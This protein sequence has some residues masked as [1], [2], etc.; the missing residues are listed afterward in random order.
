MRTS[1]ASVARALTGFFAI[2]LVAV[3]AGTLCWHWQVAWVRDRVHRIDQGW[4]D[5]APHTSW[6]PWFLAAVVV[7]AVIAGAAA[8]IAILRPN[9]ITEIDAPGIASGRITLNVNKIAQAAA[10]ELA[11]DSRISDS[12]G[13]SFN[14]G[15]RQ[16]L[17]LT[18]TF[19]GLTSPAELS[20]LLSRVTEHTQ[21]ALGPHGIPIEYLLHVDSGATTP[22]VQ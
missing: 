2:V 15:R 1:T 8:L 12:A 6:W 13:R 9:R 11:T 21:T 19:A 10:S 7:V 5:R 16:V 22:R 20:E 4:F 18:A 17:R 14:D 3:G